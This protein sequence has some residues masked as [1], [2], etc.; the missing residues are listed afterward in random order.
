MTNLEK[1]KELEKIQCQ[2]GN[3]DH[4]PYMHGMANGLILAVATLEGREPVYLEAP[5]E[6]GKDRQPP[7]DI[8]VMSASLH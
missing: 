4:D 7:Q 5:K 1:L 6:W 8:E 2:P 3:W